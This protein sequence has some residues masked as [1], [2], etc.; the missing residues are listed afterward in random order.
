MTSQTVA[1]TATH[2]TY[3]TI[4]ETEVHEALKLWHN[5]TSLQ[6]PL[7]DLLL[8]QQACHQGA[9][10]REACNQVLWQGL[11]AMTL[12][13]PEG[14]KLLRLR[15]CEKLSMRILMNRL[16][17]A[18]PTLYAR[19][20][21]AIQHLALTLQTLETEA[22]KTYQSELESRLALPPR[23]TLIGVA[24]QVTALTQHLLTTEDTPPIIALEGLGGIGKTTLAN[25]LI[26]QPSL[27]ARFAGLAWVSAKQQEL[28]PGL[29][30]V[31]ITRPALEPESLVDALLAQLDPHISP[32]QPP[33]AKQLALKMLLQKPHLVVIDNLETVSDYQ[34]LL[35][36]LR[37]LS[38]PS[39]FVLTSRH[40]LRMHPDIYCHRLSELNQTDTLT[41]IRQEARRRGLSQLEAA[42]DTQLNRIYQ[43]VGGNPLTLKLVIGQLTF[44][45]FECVIESLSRAHAQP[46]EDLFSYIYRQ[47]WETL[48]PVSRQVMLVMPL[49]QQGTFD[50]LLALT[51]LEAPTLSRAL[52]QLMA[53]S[54]IEIG[55]SLDNPC[56]TIHRLTETFILTEELLWKEWTEAKTPLTL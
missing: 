22:R 31:D 34:V 2:V 35:P 50:Y 41:L 40:S 18:E 10:P 15:Y 8:Y 16:N 13:Q 27:C 17:L 36:S 51:E 45:P 53:L 30:L 24:D 14:A 7:T 47:I 46:I 26:R 25:A 4:T 1:S 19:Q 29:G 43:Q 21:T 23:S 49:A 42:P 3:A 28:S 48:D 20:K 5:T 54:L 56:Y 32:V 12:S 11:E 33:P 38:G 9:R 55:G 44:L 37:E 39:R 6:T 52:Q